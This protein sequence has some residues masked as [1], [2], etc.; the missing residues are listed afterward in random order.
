MSYSF[1]ERLR[2]ALKEDAKNRLKTKLGLSQ[3][4]ADKLMDNIRRVCPI[5]DDMLKSMRE[6]MPRFYDKNIDVIIEEMT[7]AEFEDFL[8]EWV[9]R[10]LV[11]LGMKQKSK[12]EIEKENAEEKEDETEAEEKEVEAEAETEE[13][14]AECGDEK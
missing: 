10:A 13:A 5:S 14:E 2:I 3:K 1:R 6:Q 12:E 9:E 7:D 4:D 8:A 11:K